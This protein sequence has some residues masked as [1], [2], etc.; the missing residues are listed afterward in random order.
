[1]KLDKNNE[2]NEDEIDNI[3]CA[4]MNDPIFVLIWDEMKDFFMPEDY[5]AGKRVCF[6]FFAAGICKAE[7]L[8]EVIEMI[9]NEMV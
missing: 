4:L 2:L 8:Q 5:E 6:N 1:M 9:K 3:R 7:R